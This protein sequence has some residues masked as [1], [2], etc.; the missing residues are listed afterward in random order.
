MLVGKHKSVIYRTIQGW[1]HIVTP[2]IRGPTHRYTRRALKFMI[3]ASPAHIW[4]ML[5]GKHEGVIYRT[6]QGWFHVVTPHYERTH[7]Q[8]QKKGPKIHDKW[9]PSTY[10]M[11]AGGET[12]RS[13]LWNHTGM[14]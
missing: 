5:V 10:M 14:V 11:D 7:P 3:S 8:L 12:W 13:D 6:I 9:L 1:F 4:W 2:T